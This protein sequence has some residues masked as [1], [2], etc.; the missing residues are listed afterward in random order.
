MF[1][2][3]RVAFM[4]GAV[5]FSACWPK[6]PPEPESPPVI[7]EDPDGGWTACTR[8]CVRLAEL[9]CDEAKPTPKGTP[10][11]KVCEDA[12][13]EGIDLTCGGA[14]LTASSCEAARCR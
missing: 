8:A 4:F 1:N 10:C 9:G 6:P 7:I 3:S 13:A 12:A 14:V 11:K 5:S 2:G